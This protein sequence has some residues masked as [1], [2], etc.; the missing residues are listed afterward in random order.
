MQ[1]TQ[2]AWRD[3]RTR[4]RA[5]L[6]LA[7][8]RSDTRCVVRASTCVTSVKLP[9]CA[10]SRFTP[11]DRKIGRTVSSFKIISFGRPDHDILRAASSIPRPLRIPL[12][13]AKHLRAYRVVV[14]IF[15][16]FISS[17]RILKLYQ[18]T[19]RTRLVKTSIRRRF[20]FVLDT[21]SVKQL[22]CALI[23]GYT[24][25][26]QDQTH[27][28]KY[29]RIRCINVSQKSAESQEDRIKPAVLNI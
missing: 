3:V 20:I 4:L 9:G 23:D 18:T 10:L 28:M 17:C 12:C 1:T 27:G 25:G 7:K 24:K 13:S 8:A 22:V 14:H 16:F 26:S 19:R 6:R 2:A 21:N 5:L 11:T 29:V 15:R